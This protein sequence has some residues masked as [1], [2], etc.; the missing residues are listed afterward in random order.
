LNELPF[1]KTYP[2]TPAEIFRAIDNQSV[3]QEAGERL[4]EK[5]GDRRA[6]EVIA[7]L[8]EKM[9]IELSEE[10]GRRITHIG[11]LIDEFYGM[12]IETRPAKKRNGKK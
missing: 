11:Q 8:Q 12:I 7:D 2:K 6:M 1:E 9:G 3:N 5:Y 4:I 10:A